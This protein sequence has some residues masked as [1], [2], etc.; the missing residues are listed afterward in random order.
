MMAKGKHA[1]AVCIGEALVGFVNDIMCVID[2]YLLLYHSK[3]PKFQ[4]K[5]N[6]M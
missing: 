6:P 1:K 3:V 4:A 5:L 2:S